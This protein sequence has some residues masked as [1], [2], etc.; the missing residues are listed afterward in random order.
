MVVDQA[1]HL[2]VEKAKPRRPSA[3]ERGSQ[4]QDHVKMNVCILGNAMAV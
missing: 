2:L 1:M 3:S 4:H